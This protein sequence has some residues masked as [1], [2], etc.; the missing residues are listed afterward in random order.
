MDEEK[1]SEFIKDL[2]KK[3]TDPGWMEIHRKMGFATTLA[4]IAV[5]DE[6]MDGEMDG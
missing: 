4:D 1:K 2:M 5:L 3:A 6:A